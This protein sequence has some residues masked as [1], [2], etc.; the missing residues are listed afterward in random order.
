MSNAGGAL[1]NPDVVFEKIALGPGMRVAD[2]GCGRTGHF[3][4]PASKIVGE[5]GIV[6][7]VEIVKNILESI[8]SRARS[9]GCTNVQ[10]VWSD[11]EAFGKTP[12]P[13]KSVQACFMVNV[14]FLV[15]DK[16]SALQE[17]ARLLQQ[18]GVAVVVD[19]E[20][21]LGPLG[22]KE[23]MMVSQEELKET[24]AKAGLNYVE[25]LPVGEYH[26]C[27]LFKKV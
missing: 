15:K 3:V 25:S 17:A 26:F 6:Y 5:S 18:N 12:I 1:I 27:A 20:K 16:M 21:N 22:P 8:K 23:G 24:A 14:L 11:I 9:E 19:W 2:L 13:S 10:A 4:F 7:A